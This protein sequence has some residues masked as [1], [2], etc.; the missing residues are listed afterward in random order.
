MSSTFK[1]IIGGSEVFPY[2]V[3]WKGGY[4][5][6]GPWIAAP[7]KPD[8]FAASDRIV[9]REVTA[10]GRIFAAL[11]SDEMVFSNSIDG[12]RSKNENREELICLLAVLNSKFASFY[13][14][15]K[16]GNSQKDAFPKILLKD[17]RDFPLPQ[18][19]SSTE[20]N[21][22]ATRLIKGKNPAE[23]YPELLQE[24]EKLVHKLY[25]LTEEEIKMIEGN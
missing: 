24:I 14:I 15:N 25:S 22:L 6:Y 23:L 11:I 19:F 17:L 16:S 5:N 13:H 12:I 20:L 21:Q 1:P 9:V 8:W 2:K 4:I 10:K 7:R 18:E 3:N